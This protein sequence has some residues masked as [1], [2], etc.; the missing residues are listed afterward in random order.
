MPFPEMHAGLAA[1]VAHSVAQHYGARDITAHDGYVNYT[2][3][4]DERLVIKAPKGNEDGNGASRLEALAIESVA[5][6]LLEGVDVSPVAIPKIIEFSLDPAYLVTSYVPGRTS[7][8]REELRALSAKK[9]EALGR[10]LGAHIVRQAATIN[11]QMVRE[12]IPCSSEQRWQ[13]IFDDYIPFS[14]TNY[15][16][17]SRFTADLYEHWRVYQASTTTTRQF[18]HADLTFSNIGVSDSYTLLSVFDYARAGLGTLAEELSPLVP[19]DDKLLQGCLNEL[20]K[21]TGKAPN[22]EHVWLWRN[23]KDTY[24]L[25]YWIAHENTLHPFYIKCRQIITNRYPH[26]DWSELY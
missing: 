14:H 8:P 26:L 16:T 11:L 23:M 18:I 24:V 20:E 12:S 17:L 9:R 1:D 13:K 6:E 21:T 25:P 3:T 2:I 19:I 10:S 4:A 15:P 5:L 7:V 22:P